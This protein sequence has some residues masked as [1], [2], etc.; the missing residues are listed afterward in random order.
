VQALLLALAEE[1]GVKTEVKVTGAGTA[2]VEVRRLT[3]S[4]RQFVFV[5]SHSEQTADATISLDLPWTP[6]HARDL[7]ADSEVI[8]QAKGGATVLHRKL[9][10]HEIWVVSLERE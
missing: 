6:Q 4:D 10:A 1:A 7:T 8:F 2:E 5:F 3:S 9:E